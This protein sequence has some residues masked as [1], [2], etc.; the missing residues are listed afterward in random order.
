MYIPWLCFDQKMSRTAISKTLIWLF[1]LTFF[2][3]KS[4]H[5][6]AKQ[7]KANQLNS[8]QIMMCLLY[9]RWLWKKLFSAFCHNFWI[10]YT[11][12]KCSSLNVRGIGW[13]NDS[14]FQTVMVCVEDIFSTHLWHVLRYFNLLCNVG[15]QLYLKIGGTQ[16]WIQYAWNFTY[17]M[18]MS[19]TQKDQLWAK[20]LNFSWKNGNVQ[21]KH[22]TLGKTFEFFL[23][24][25]LCPI[26]ML[27]FG[28][29]NVICCKS[30]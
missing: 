17:K 8:A 25:W 7:I 11:N 24:K 3:I 27:N 18:A 22:W 1:G 21:T 20:P 15:K 29:N 13:N 12:Y 16:R 30:K 6:K 23:E 9:W 4:N 2:Q 19:K 10:C 26:Q 14:Q 5:T 28:Q